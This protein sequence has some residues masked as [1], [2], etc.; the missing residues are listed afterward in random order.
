MT[1]KLRIQ[2]WKYTARHTRRPPGYTRREGWTCWAYNTSEY[3][4]F[5][6]SAWMKTNMVGKYDCDLKFNGG[7]P[8]Y[9]VYIKEQR[10]AEF[11]AL[12]FI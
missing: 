6:I 7:D 12:N 3:L 9:V 4:D 11:F 10:D 5:D 8:I 2:H 1:S